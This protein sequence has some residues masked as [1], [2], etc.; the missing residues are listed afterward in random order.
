MSTNTNPN[1]A[2]QT[3]WTDAMDAVRGLITEKDKR[4]S[5][6]ARAY[7]IWDFRIGLGT[8]D[9]TQTGARQV[10]PKDE[11]ACN[12]VCGTA[13]TCPTF[14]PGTAADGGTSNYCVFA[15]GELDP[16]DNLV[17]LFESYKT[18]SNRTPDPN[19]MG[20]TPLA[21][22]LCQTLDTIRLA[23]RNIP[24]T[25]TLEADGMENNSTLGNC[26]NWQIASTAVPYSTE[27]NASWNKGQSDWGMS[28]LSGSGAPDAIGNNTYVPGGGSWQARVVRRSLH[29]NQPDAAAATAPAIAANETA[30]TNLA[31]RVHAHFTTFG[32]S[33]SSLRAAPTLMSLPTSSTVS[34]QRDTAP[35]QYTVKA[36]LAGVS[37]AMLASSSLA[38]V[39]TTYAAATIITD[40]PTGELNL[41]RQL[42]S[43]SFPSP[44]ASRSVF[45]A[46]TLLPGQTYGTNHVFPGDVDDSGCVDRADYSIMTQQDVWY[47]RALPPLQI[48]MRADLNKDGWV[49]EADRAI[50]IADWGHGCINPV[51]PPPTF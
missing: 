25:I 16:Y 11:A 5:T 31:W 24:Q 39:P 22:A 36:S 13:A 32:S 38:A 42:A 27:A 6:V 30:E 51:G 45:Q 9:P 8:N 12:A 41:F 20:R 48:A 28:A 26:G 18:D 50:L 29:M 47:G 33:S 15:A 14:L 3:R 1:N 7:A 43:P 10:W 23:D 49:N 37:S 46:F 17:A 2:A 21:Q 34:S 4:S 35:Q 40:I 44:G 19:F